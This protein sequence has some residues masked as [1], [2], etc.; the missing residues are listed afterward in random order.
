[1][2]VVE[3]ITDGKHRWCPYF[4]G[5]K[6]LSDVLS[7]L[8]VGRRT[9]SMDP[10][11]VEA[12]ARSAGRCMRVSTRSLLTADTKQSFIPLIGTSQQWPFTPCAIRHSNTCSL[13]HPFTPLPSSA[14][15]CAQPHSERRHETLCSAGESLREPQLMS[16]YVPQV[17]E[18]PVKRSVSGGTRDTPA[19]STVPVQH[20]IRTTR[21]P[22]LRLIR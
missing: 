13:T 4:H 5:V 3:V 9:F 20:H 21:L 6:S 15:F 18:L 14:C 10:L 12:S 8:V 7:G 22:V 19:E 17:V 16:L 11:N 2:V 1:M